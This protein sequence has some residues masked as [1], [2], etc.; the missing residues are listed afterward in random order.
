MAFGWVERCCAYLGGRCFYR[1]AY[2]SG[3]RLL[4]RRELLHVPKAAAAL[5]G[6]R[7]VHLS[8]LHAGPFLGAGDLAPVVARVNSLAPDL[9]D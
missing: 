4:V 9:E 2:L 3:G 6:L 1:H 5:A 7:I 8:D